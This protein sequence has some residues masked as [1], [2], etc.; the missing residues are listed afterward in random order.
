MTS[1]TI[2]LSADPSTFDMVEVIVNET[3]S[4]PRYFPIVSP[5]LNTSYTAVGT[6]GIKCSFSATSA[7][8]SMAMLNNNPTLIR[9]YR[10]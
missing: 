5:K 6:S 4:Y 7:T 3:Q 2:P 10:F 9:G 1:D 8:I